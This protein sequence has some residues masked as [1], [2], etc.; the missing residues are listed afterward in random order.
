MLK[1]HRTHYIIKNKPYLSRQAIEMLIPPPFINDA[2]NPYQKVNKC[3]VIPLRF[4]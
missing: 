3:K 4:L 2:E 1:T